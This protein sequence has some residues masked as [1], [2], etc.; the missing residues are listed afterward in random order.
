MSE[1]TSIQFDMLVPQ[2]VYPAAPTG[3]KQAAG[4]MEC[5]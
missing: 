2:L 1:N 4:K 5:T 3:Q